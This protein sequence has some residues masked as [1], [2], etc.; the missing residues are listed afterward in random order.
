MN[1]KVVILTCDQ[2]PKRDHSGHFTEGGAY[3]LCVATKLEAELKSNYEGYRGNR[4]V[5]PFTV[6]PNGR[7]G[8][9]RKYT[10]EIPDWCPLPF[11]KEVLGE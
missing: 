4:A 2:C 9:Y 7:G 1:R 11:D 10:G 5:L 8:M 6:E 3:P